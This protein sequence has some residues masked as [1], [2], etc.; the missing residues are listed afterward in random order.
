MSER[1]C[2]TC[3]RRY[4]EKLLQTHTSIKNGL[5]WYEPECPICALNRRNRE[6]GMPP[7]SK[8]P[9]HAGGAKAYEQAV[10]HLKQSGQDLKGVIE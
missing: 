2:N 9:P 6:S 7:D 5:P 8:F 1:K 10:K 3:L 4:P